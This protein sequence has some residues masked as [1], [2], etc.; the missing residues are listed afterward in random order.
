MLLAFEFEYEQSETRL[1]I[2]QPRIGPMWCV[3]TGASV[4][5]AL[6]NIEGL[7]GF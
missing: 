7:S 5:R 3:G 6:H 1:H 2:D 4:D